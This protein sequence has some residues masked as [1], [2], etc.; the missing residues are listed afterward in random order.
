MSDVITETACVKVYAACVNN[1]EET[2]AGTTART[3]QT[4]S[5][6]SI[7]LHARRVARRG[8]VVAPRNRHLASIRA[9][10]DVAGARE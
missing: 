7:V 1:S 4:S 5:H 2:P 10:V 6:R 3:V 8:V 9:D